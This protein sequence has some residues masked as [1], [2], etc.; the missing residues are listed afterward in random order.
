MDAA[1]E[2]TGMYLQRV[3]KSDG[4]LS[5]VKRLRETSFPKQPE[6]QTQ[7]HADD[8]GRGDGEVKAK[9]FLFNCNIT[10]QTKPA[11]FLQEGPQ[12]AN[13]N[14]HNANDDERALHK[15]FDDFNALFGTQ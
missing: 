12:Q 5:P 7:D 15:L 11:H 6:D 13:A 4:H 3:L 9:V 1:V 2:R 14:Q 10:R 8:N